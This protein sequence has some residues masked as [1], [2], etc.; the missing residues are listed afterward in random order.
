M[1]RRK[2]KN[3]IQRLFYW[4]FFAV[5]VFAGVSAFSYSGT[6]K[7]AHV[8]DIHL[9]DKSAN[10]SYKVLASSNALLNDEIEQLNSIPNLDLVLVSGDMTDR[11]YEEM[12]LKFIKKMNTL[13]APW[14]PAFGNHDIAIFGDL[15]KKRYIEI[16]NENNPNYKSKKSYYSFVPKKGFRVIAMDAII[17]D[18]ITANG[19]VP[20]EE[21]NWLDN[22]LCKAKRNDE[23]PLIFLHHPLHEP[24]SSFHHRILNA[25]E[26]Y[27]VLNKY[28]MPMA[29]M[30]GHYHCTKVTKEGN[31]LHLSTPALVSYPNAFRI[32]TVTNMKNK[33]VFKYD[34][35]ETRLTD[36]QKSAKLLTFSSKNYYGTESDRN[37]I[38]VIDK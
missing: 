32:I 4:V 2:K 3:P 36:V 20:Q 28:K 17:D 38:V 1:A 8:S 37:G 16:L 12:V 9:S 30:T 35:K 21:L 7:F 33:V 15:T 19:K 34:F 11:P 25:D 29:V 5:C 26:F 23:V 14:Y 13:K 24:F 31:I 27:A 18:K 22:E 10:T 6:L